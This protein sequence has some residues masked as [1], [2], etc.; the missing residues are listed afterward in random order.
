MRGCPAGGACVVVRGV[1]VVAG[2]GG[3]H[4]CWGVCV[5]AGGACIGY[6]EIRSISG[7]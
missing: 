1:C 3:V 6:D 2:G 5:I 4:G 7:R